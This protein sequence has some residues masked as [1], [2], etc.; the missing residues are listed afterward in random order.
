M[1]ELRIDSRVRDTNLKTWKALITPARRWDGS[2]PH[3]ES[4][5]QFTT[6]VL[7]GSTVRFQ[8]RLTGS[9]LVFRSFAPLGTT[10]N[11]QYHIIAHCDHGAEISGICRLPWKDDDR[12]GLM[13][14]LCCAETSASPLPLHRFRRDMFPARNFNRLYLLTCRLGGTATARQRAVPP[15]HLSTRQQGLVLM[16][17]GTIK[18][19]RFL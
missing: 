16:A 19:N 2:L 3:F 17:L 10:S 11:H 14:C 15:G 18:A 5:T 7:F 12:V 4:S 9:E 13:P 1:N 6:T 8:H